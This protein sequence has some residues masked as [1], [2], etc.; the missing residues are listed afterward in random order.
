MRVY[1]TTVQLAAYPGGDTIPAGTQDLA[2]RAASRVVEACVSLRTYAVDVDGMP[3]NA[4]D[5]QAM[6]D[7]TCAIA[8]EAYTTGAFEAGSSQQWESVRIGNVQL[9]N[10]QGASSADS[11]VIAGLPVPP[12]AVNALLGVGEVS[13][14]F[15]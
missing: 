4:D 1:A 13:V 9:Q 6:A 14:S 10:L 12:V 15:S 5:V 3:T 2:L 8:V 7:A 11:P